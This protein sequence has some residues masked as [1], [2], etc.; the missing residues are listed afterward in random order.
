MKRTPLKIGILLAALH[1]ALVA[2]VVSLLLRAGEPDWPMYWLIFFFLDFPVT[3]LYV[4]AGLLVDV[5]QIPRVLP[6][7]GPSAVGDVL[8]FILPIFFYGIFGTLW[9]FYLPSLVSR[10][11]QRMRGGGKS[12]S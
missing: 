10:V 4:G 9:Y 7:P 3:L 6:L 11:I 5:F 8:N 1:L 12:K 2:Y